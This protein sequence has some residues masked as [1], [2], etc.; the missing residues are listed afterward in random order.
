M[1]PLRLMNCSSASEAGLYT[2]AYRMTRDHLLRVRLSALAGS[3]VHRM[4]AAN[5]FSR[6]NR[7]NPCNRRAV[8]GGVEGDAL[9]R[10]TRS[11]QKPGLHLG[12]PRLV[13]L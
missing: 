6:S 3:A 9:C 13:Q 2:A 10:L 5:T 7:G 11:C 12:S 8:N 1:P 4:M